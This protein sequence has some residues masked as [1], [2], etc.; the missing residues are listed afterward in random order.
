M[1]TRTER[2]AKEQQEQL[3]QQL[4]RESLFKSKKR[5]QKILIN[6]NSKRN[7][8]KKF[9][10]CHFIFFIQSYSLI[11]NFASSSLSSVALPFIYTLQSDLMIFRIASSRSMSSCNN[12]FIKSNFIYFQINIYFKLNLS[13]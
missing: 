13:A 6:E 12:N 1:Q 8:I 11:V 4:S 10:C 3:E 5:K 2:M 9:F 7:T